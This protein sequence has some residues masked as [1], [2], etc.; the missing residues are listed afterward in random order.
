[1]IND[2]L[3]LSKI[4]AGRMELHLESFSLAPLIEDCVK[5]IETLAAKNANRVVVHCDPGIKTMHAHQI[6][7]RQALL[8]LVSNANKF[9]NRGTITINGEQ[10]DESGRDLITIAVTDTG[11]GMMAEQIGKLFQEFSQA[12]SST[13]KKYGRTGLGLAISERFCQMMAGISPS[14]ASLAA[15]R[16]SRSGCQGLLKTQRKWWLRGIWPNRQDSR[17]AASSQAH[18][19]ILL[20]QDR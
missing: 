4:E 15:G 5:T 8:N 9:T 20:W 10:H 17:Q 2:I 19:S 14:K 13:A 16:P 3:D 12:E 18:Y 1:L 6:R 11:V 7:V